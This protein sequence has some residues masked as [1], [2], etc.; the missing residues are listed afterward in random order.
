MRDWSLLN[1]TVHQ[2]HACSLLLMFPCK[3]IKGR[4]APILPRVPLTAC[5][6]ERE[7][8]ECATC[9]S[10]LSFF[11]SL[12][13]SRNFVFTPLLPHIGCFQN[14]A[15]TL[16]YPRTMGLGPHAGCHISWLSKPS[17]FLPVDDRHSPCFSCQGRTIYLFLSSGTHTSRGT[18]I[19]LHLL[20]QS[21]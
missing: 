12:I 16:H 11:L 6:C 21:M 3:D 9:Y 14:E 18:Q 17:G 1:R 5:G 13:W 7:P 20:E 15:E 4:V 8:D 19:K 10:L 2:G